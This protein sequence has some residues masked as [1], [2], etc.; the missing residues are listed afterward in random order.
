MATPYVED[1]TV[2]YYVSRTSL[3]FEGAILTM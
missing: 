3:S 1:V 2:L